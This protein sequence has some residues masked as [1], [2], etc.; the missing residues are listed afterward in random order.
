MGFN[1]KETQVE[2]TNS[3][4]VKEDRIMPH[5]CLF[6]SGIESHIVDQKEVLYKL[7]KNRTRIIVAQNYLCE[8]T[9]SEIPP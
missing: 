8:V 7:K 2:S 9:R 6:V 4:H 1:K 3:Y 5:R